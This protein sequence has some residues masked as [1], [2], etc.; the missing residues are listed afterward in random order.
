[1]RTFYT[2]DRIAVRENKLFWTLEPGIERPT[3]LV[4]MK[5]AHAVKARNGD[6]VVHSGR[7]VTHASL[8]EIQKAKITEIEVDTTDLDGAF[9]A[10]DVVDTNTGEVL[11]EANSEITVDKLSKI[12]DTGVG[13]IHVFF[14]VERDRHCP[15]QPRLALRR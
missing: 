15:R 11:L 12:M 8:K 14:L 3:N 7:K 4:G 1:M 2:V 9:T 6:E 10:A 13:E 5:L